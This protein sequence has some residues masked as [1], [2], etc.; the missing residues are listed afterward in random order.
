MSAE[1][2]HW[3][4]AVAVTMILLGGVATYYFTF[5]GFGILGP[6]ILFGPIL[7]T[8]GPILL[9]QP[10]PRPS[11]ATPGVWLVVGG[12]VMMAPSLVLVM[13]A[14]AARGG[15]SEWGMLATISLMYLAGPALLM[16]IVGI[17]RAARS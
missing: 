4:K 1:K 14:K 13:L 12:L 8:L 11:N 9:W 10:R 7:L 3:V 5:F 6:L 16:V 15:D 2:S 17:I